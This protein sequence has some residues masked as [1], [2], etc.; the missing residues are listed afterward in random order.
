MKPPVH[1]LS[2]NHKYSPPAGGATRD[3]GCSATTGKV[4]YLP[5]QPE[6]ILT[7]PAGESDQSELPRSGPTNAANVHAGNAPRASISTASR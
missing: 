5:D 4:A 2:Q 6:C 3:G 7:A 1:V